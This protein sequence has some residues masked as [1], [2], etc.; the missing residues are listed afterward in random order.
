MT[1]PFDILL[2]AAVYTLLGLVW[3]ALVVAIVLPV[4][5]VARLFQRLGD[6]QPKM[7]HGGRV[8]VRAHRPHS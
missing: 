4:V 5:L 2:V 8:L 7:R 1:F 6:H 3:S